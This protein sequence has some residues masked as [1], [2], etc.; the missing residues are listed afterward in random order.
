MKPHTTHDM[1]MLQLEAAFKALVA[2]EA[3]REVSHG[4]LGNHVTKN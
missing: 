2:L 3:V 4:T 1:R